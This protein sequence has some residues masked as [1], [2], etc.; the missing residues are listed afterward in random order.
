VTSACS[1]PPTPVAPRHR[2]LDL[3]VIR[4]DPYVELESEVVAHIDGERGSP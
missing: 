1:K 4:P 2:D 3:Q